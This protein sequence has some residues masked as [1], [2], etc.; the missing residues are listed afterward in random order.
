MYIDGEV[1]CKHFF[2]SLFSQIYRR[3]IHIANSLLHLTK[4]LHN[5]QGRILILQVHKFHL[6]MFF[7]LD[8]YFIPLGSHV[9]KAII[10][11]LVQLYIINPQMNIISD[12]FLHK[13]RP[14]EQ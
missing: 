12:I 9:P 10:K 13:Q 11:I 1:S 14:F 8:F 6:A 2:V 5:H 3:E 7:S 4:G